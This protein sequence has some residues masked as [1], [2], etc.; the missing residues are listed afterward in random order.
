MEGTDC[1]DVVTVSK[2]EEKHSFFMTLRSLLLF[3]LCDIRCLII[4]VK[5]SLS[6]V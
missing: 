2:I 4:L 6:D 5:N 1:G 3:V